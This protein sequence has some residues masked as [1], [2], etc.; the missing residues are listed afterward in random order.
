MPI[1][2]KSHW[3]DTCTCDWLTPAET[4]INITMIGRIYNGFFLCLYNWKKRR[5]LFINRLFEKTVGKWCDCVST[6]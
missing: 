5:D 2:I 1:C 6:V 3:F 4:F